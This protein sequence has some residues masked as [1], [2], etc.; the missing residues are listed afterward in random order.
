MG[1]KPMVAPMTSTYF[2]RSVIQLLEL[3]KIYFGS[4]ISA[5]STS[6]FNNCEIVALYHQISIV[7]IYYSIFK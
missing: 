3:W 6:F 7:R 1:I 2:D 5:E 4:V